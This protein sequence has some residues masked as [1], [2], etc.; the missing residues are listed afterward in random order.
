MLVATF[1]VMIG[2][3]ARNHLPRLNHPVFAAPGFDRASADRFVL[4]ILAS[5]PRFE[6]H[7]TRAFLEG[8]QTPAPVAVEEVPL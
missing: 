4:C 3:L 7:D 1:A 5:D 8:L 2:M 6:R